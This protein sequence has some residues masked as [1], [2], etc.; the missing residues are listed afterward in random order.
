MIKVPK[1][2]IH[3]L[4]KLNKIKTN[5]KNVLLFKYLSINNL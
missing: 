1:S 2:K 3:P 4:N 5:E